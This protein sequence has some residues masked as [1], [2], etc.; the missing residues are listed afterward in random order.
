MHVAT[1][2]APKATGTKTQ[3]ARQD[4]IWKLC[5]AWASQAD[6]RRRWF[7]GQMK[8]EAQKLQKAVWAELKSKYGYEKE[9][10]E[11]P[12]IE[13]TETWLGPIEDEEEKTTT[14]RVAQ[15][16]EE[17]ESSSEKATSKDQHDDDDDDDDEVPDDAARNS[18][19]RSRKKFVQWDD[20]ETEFL[21]LEMH[22]M[23]RSDPGAQVVHLLNEAQKQLPANRHRNITTVSQFEPVLRKLTEVD[24]QVWNDHEHMLKYRE[25]VQE[26]KGAPTRAEVFASATEEELVEFF[27]D[28]VLD[29]ALPIEIVERLGAQAVLEMLPLSQIAA[30]VM[31]KQMECFGRLNDVEDLMWDIYARFDQKD[32]GQ[33]ASPISRQAQERESNGFAKKPKVVFYGL[34]PRQQQAVMA[35]LGGKVSFHFVDKKREQDAVPPS[36]DIII[37]WARYCSHSLQNTVRRDIPD[38][39]EFVLHHGGVGE[40]VAKVNEC[41]QKLRCHA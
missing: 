25:K 33:K 29:N 3:N 19:K 18:E 11:E 39:C 31:V 34:L 30:F 35:R 6:G 24:A 7:K 12:T 28:R 14:N 38:G 5:E 15:H 1:L 36:A 17:I 26:Q 27:Q 37:F 21:A 41:L 13:P 32:S 4:R 9:W 20:D 16:F 2:E 40:M 22:R 23:R 10:D 8:K